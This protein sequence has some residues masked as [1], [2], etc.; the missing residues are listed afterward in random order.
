VSSQAFTTIFPS[1]MTTTS[2]L[3]LGR[4]VKRTK[5]N[6]NSNESGSKSIEWNALAF[7]VLVKNPSSQWFSFGIC[8][9]NGDVEGVRRS[10]KNCYQYFTNGSLYHCGKLVKRYSKTIRDGDLLR[11]L[12]ERPKLTSVHKSN[13]SDDTGECGFVT[14]YIN[15]NRVS[16]RIKVSKEESTTPLYASALLRQ[17]GHA[18][19]IQDKPSFQHPQAV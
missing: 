6:S 16:D 8:D 13:D 17:Y 3:P 12:L 18:L 5:S 7:E 1:I 4:I 15:G 10:P 19:T 14:F 9:I 2:P 11:F